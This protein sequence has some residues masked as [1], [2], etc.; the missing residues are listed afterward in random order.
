MKKYNVLKAL[1][2]NVVIAVNEEHEEVVL[3]GKGIGFNKKRNDVIE[4]DT[5][6]KLFVLRDKKEQESYIKLLPNMD[7]TTLAA[8]IT[9][10]EIIKKKSNALLNEKV[11]V[12]LTDHILFAISRLQRG[13]E[14]RN[15][16]LSETKALYPLEY[17]IAAEVVDYM[18]Q[19]LAIQLPEGEV[20]FIALHVHSAI[21]ETTISEISSYS[22]LLSTLVE[23]IEEQLHIEI[24]R[25]EIDYIRLIRHLR[26]TI[27]RVL[28]EEVMEEPAKIAILLKKEYPVCYNLAWKLIKI[29]QQTLKKPV[30]DAE[31]VYL[32]MHLQRL[33]V[34]FD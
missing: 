7:E 6:E 29:M 21:T 26:Y 24:D 28:K 23:T 14:I 10:M 5:V 12:A 31:A 13:L 4:E 11:H 18:N 16:F 22:N 33:V 2:N 3:I 32:T 1:N 9:A 30:Y 27:E 19:T 8:I 15:P 25:E 34:K 17:E 20:G